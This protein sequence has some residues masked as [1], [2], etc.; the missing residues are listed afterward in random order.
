MEGLDEVISEFLVESYESL[1][2]LD[3]DLMA[4]EDC[5]DDR[6]RLVSIFRTV[7]TIKG[8]S[9]F[10][11]LPKLERVAHVGENLLVPLRDGGHS[12]CS[13]VVMLP[14]RQLVSIA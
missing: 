3:R 10:L 12:R 1:D 14:P 7:H 11:A 13:V 2:Q 8:T 9:G 5:P 6:A 4:L